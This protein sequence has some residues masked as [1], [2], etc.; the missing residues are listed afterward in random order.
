MSGALLLDE[1]MVSAQPSLVRAFGLTNAVVLQQVHW[2]HVYGDGIEHD[3]H[4]WFPVTYAGLA[5]ELGLS[6]EQV[7]RA[8]EYLEGEELLISCQ[9]EGRTSRRKWYRVNRAHPQIP[10]VANPPDRKRRTRQMG[11]GESAASSTSQPSEPE[12]ATDKPS[13]PRARFLE[14]DALVEAFG[15]PGTREEEAFYAKTARSL[16][17][18]GKPPTE[19]VDRGKRARARHETCT[20]NVLLTRWSNF[21]PPRGQTPGSTLDD[22]AT[23]DRE[24]RG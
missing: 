6:A 22:V 21:A 2:H 1:R 24:V 7:R 18:Q 17:A 9:P 19:I 11:T 20:V 4:A 23:R 16:K 5:E 3:G 8:V 14:Y 13:K 10:E 15:V 12:A